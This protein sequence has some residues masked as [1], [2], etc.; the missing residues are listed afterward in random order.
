MIFEISGLLVYLGARIK[1][2]AKV[3][4]IRLKKVVG[5]VVFESQNAFVEG[6]RILDAV[7]FANEC[8]DSRLKS[9]ISESRSSWMGFGEKWRKWIYLR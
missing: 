1:L 9:G 2:L 8:L 3:L 6:R 7:L 4:A 5:K